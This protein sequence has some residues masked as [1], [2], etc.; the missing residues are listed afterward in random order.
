MVSPN[1]AG[2]KSGD[3][4]EAV[5]QR[6]GLTGKLQKILK[7]MQI[8]SYDSVTPE[9]LAESANSWPTTETLPPVEI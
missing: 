1:F 5:V 4:F 6:H 7:V 8:E 3:W 9:S 2:L